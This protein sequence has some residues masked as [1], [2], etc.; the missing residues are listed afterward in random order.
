MG[1]AAKKWTVKYYKGLGTSSRQD[2]IKYF[3]DLEFHKKEFIYE[4]AQ[5]RIPNTNAL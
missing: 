1:N 4:G 5:W 2:A 3:Q